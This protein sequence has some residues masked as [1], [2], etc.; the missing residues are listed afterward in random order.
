MGRRQRL[1]WHHA[2]DEGAKAA[3]GGKIGKFAK[4]LQL[5]A[6]R[7]GDRATAIARTR[8]HVPDAGIDPKKAPARRQDLQGTGK[9]QR[10][11]R[12]RHDVVECRTRC[13]VLRGVVDD[14]RGTE[15]HD[16]FPVTTTGDARDDGASIACQLHERT[17]HR[18][19][20]AHHQHA[21]ACPQLR[22]AQVVARRGATEPQRCRSFD[23]HPLW[24]RHDEASFG[25][26]GVLG[27]PAHPRAGKGNDR[28]ADGKSRHLSARRHNG[29]REFHAEN[30]TPGPGEAEHG[31]ADELQSPWEVHGPDAPAGRRDSGGLDLHE[32]VAWSRLRD[33]NLAKGEH[34]GPAIGLRHPGTHGLRTWDSCHSDHSFLP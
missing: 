12:I 14:R 15:A 29:S 7:A 24:T 10:S 2:V 21:F 25:H 33:R 18:T 32:D 9:R 13:Y 3:P 5:L 31:A 8:K 26:Q 30:G 1:E 22:P 34:V 17:P 28:I 6:G 27:V 4:I 19:G 20:R 16:Q 11:G 23:R